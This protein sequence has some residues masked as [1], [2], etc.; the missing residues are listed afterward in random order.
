MLFIKNTHTSPL[1]SGL[2]FLQKTSDDKIS[3]ARKLRKKMTE[4]ERVLWFY[5]R[6]RRLCG[7]K[8]RRQQIMDGYIADFFCHE[9]KLL[10]EVDGGIHNTEPQKVIDARKESAALSRG[11]HIVR[12]ENKEIMHSIKVC[13]KKLEEFMKEI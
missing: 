7:L 13:L 4:A 10:I 11:L 8:F 9:K 1:S 3:R 6:D 2:I 12:I 5:L